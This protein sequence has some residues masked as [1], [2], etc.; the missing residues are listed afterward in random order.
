[1]H[2][3]YLQ[4]METSNA[5]APSS[6]AT[7]RTDP[8]YKE[9]KQFYKDPNAYERAKHGSYLQG[10]ETTGCPIPNSVEIRQHGSYLQGMETQP[11]R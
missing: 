9:W 3:S 1:M 4:G 11:S 6:V 7:H 8:T 5:R 2:G 10:M